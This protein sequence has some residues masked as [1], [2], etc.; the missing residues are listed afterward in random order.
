MTNTTKNSY[1]LTLVA[2]VVFAVGIFAS[3]KSKDLFQSDFAVSADLDESC[4]LRKA[5]CTSKLP[6]GGMVSFSIVPNNIPI[7]EPLKLIVNTQGL[8]ASNV[9]VDF[10]GLNMEMGIQHS[11]LLAITP[12]RFEGQYTV[13]ICTNS[14]M[15]WEARVQLQTEKGLV[16]VPFRF[17]TTK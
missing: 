6:S 14:R 2:L 1:W 12:K 5:A 11:K 13:P 15:E 7:L 4:D 9:T 16:M 3:Y 8:N 10:F 17:H